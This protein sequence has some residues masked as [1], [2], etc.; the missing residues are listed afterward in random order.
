MSTRNLIQF[1]I[2]CDKPSGGALKVRHYYEHARE[3]SN[4]TA[5]YMPPDIELRA[6]NPWFKYRHDVT[7]IID[8][9]KV[10]IMFIS[11]WG[12]QR[13][14]PHQYH[15]HRPFTVVYLVQHPRKLM[16]I[17]SRYHD[18][19]KPAIRICYS[20]ALAEMARNLGIVNGPVH[21]IPA[22][23]E[24]KPLI[25]SKSRPKS[26][27]ILIVSLKN[28]EAGRALESM[29][30]RAQIKAHVLDKLMSRELF[31]EA[32]AKARIVVCLPNASE[33]FYLPALEAMAMGALVICPDV[34]GNDYCKH[35]YNCLVPDYQCEE[36]FN[37]IQ[38]ALAMN[39]GERN[40]ILL[41]AE[42]SANQHDLSIERKRF[43]QI[44]AS[45]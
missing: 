36:M 5:I 26:I 42:I 7:R 2:R 25:D 32:L 1:A 31:L 12:W 17:D 45:I 29:L 3:W 44:L 20:G 33:G 39:A 40:R 27:D 19:R 37:A 10:N 13:F 23:I 14:I 6:S 34:F 18:L 30:V 41:N 9:D 4:N 35:N 16:P 8:W 15:F 28:Q 43:H 22:G 11:G 21:M 38:K 24:L